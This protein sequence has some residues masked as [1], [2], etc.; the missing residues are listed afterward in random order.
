MRIYNGI[1]FRRLLR[2]KKRQLKK[3]FGFYWLSPN[4][5]RDFNNKLL[6]K[7]GWFFLLANNKKI[8]VKAPRLR[9]FGWVSPTKA[10]NRFLYR[11][12][13]S[14]VRSYLLWLTK[15][16]ARFRLLPSAGVL[17]R[18]KKG[19]SSLRGFG[20]YVGCTRVRTPLFV[21]G[22]FKFAKRFY[23]R[24][25]RFYYGKLKRSLTHYQISFLHFVVW[26][27][28]LLRIWSVLNLFLV[29][30][31][32]RIMALV[33]QSMTDLYFY[34]YHLFFKREFH[35]II[36]YKGRVRRWKRIRKHQN[37]NHSQF[38]PTPSD[39][40]RGFP[41]RV[42]LW[43]R[44]QRFAVYLR[45][46]LRRSVKVQVF[47]KNRPWKQLN[48]W[49]SKRSPSTFPRRRVPLQILESTKYSQRS[50]FSYTAGGV[51]VKNS[52]LTIKKQ[53]RR[54]ALTHLVV[55]LRRNLRKYRSI[56]GF[57]DFCFLAVLY[58]FTKNA[59][60]LRQWLAYFFEP[61]SPHSLHMSQKKFLI[62]IATSLMNLQTA[63]GI[64]SAY[65]FEVKGKVDGSLRTRRLSYGV[66][67]RQHTVSQELAYV[68]YDIRT[69]TGIL[70]F[71]FWLF[72]PLRGK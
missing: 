7:F 53:R 23:N 20:G 4:R 9:R 60:G 6:L 65:R 35:L 51:D 67:S 32:D 44:G 14:G 61:L 30:L 8:V 2:Y 5:C 29:P 72:F 25:R 3:R 28:K 38:F 21:V 34:A 69:Y 19:K 68:Q 71:R 27:I 54:G 49:F 56:N 59:Q 15:G 36:R 12:R 17:A 52:F 66:D 33:L 62:L 13:C 18:F 42:R 22:G 45:K 31:S 58:V 1:H 24:S 70:G 47:Y 39:V 50:H 10:L 37:Q 26:K 11:S 63:S 55:L 64:F 46:G 57:F 41:K 40:K 43:L 48:R 16:G